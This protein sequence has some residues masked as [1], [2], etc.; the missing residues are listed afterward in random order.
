MEGRQVSFE[1]LENRRFA[2]VNGINSHGDGNVDL[3]TPVLK[4]EGFQVVDV[5]LPKRGHLQARWKSSTRED[6]R[7]IFQVTRQNDAV[8]AHSYGCLRTLRA[9]ERRRFSHIFLFRPALSRAYSLDKI[10]GSPV[11]YCFHSRGDLA[12]TVG[13]LLPF[14]VF[15]RAGTR[16]M[17]DPAVTNVQS[18]GRHNDDFRGSLFDVNMDFVLDA[19]NSDHPLT[20]HDRLRYTPA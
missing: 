6:A 9:A 12:V 13:G 20:G 5:A 4:A 8:I 19:V 7:I 16:G 10:A 1:L 14:H 18:F 3:C 15:G 2:L 17:H 11:I